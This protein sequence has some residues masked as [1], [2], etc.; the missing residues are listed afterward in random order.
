MWTAD[1]G[2]W[3]KG[4]RVTLFG[5]SD[6]DEALEQAERIIEETDFEKYKLGCEPHVVQVFNDG[7]RVWDIYSQHRKAQ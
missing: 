6:L 2:S 3:E 1:I 5:A 4:K 7:E